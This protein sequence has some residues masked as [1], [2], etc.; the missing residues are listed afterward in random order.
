MT[1]EEVSLMSLFP[2]TMLNPYTKYQ[3]PAFTE[4]S[5]QKLN[6]AQDPNHLNYLGAES[7]AAPMPTP[8]SRSA[9]K[10]AAVR[11]RNGI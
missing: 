1:P 10:G 4:H 5:I 6:L 7:F 2:E 8:F 3:P 9:Q 11:T